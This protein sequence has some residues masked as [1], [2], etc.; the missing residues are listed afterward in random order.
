MCYNNICVPSHNQ[1]FSDDGEI[2]R[3]DQNEHIEQVSNQK[4]PPDNFHMACH[5]E[6]QCALSADVYQPEVS[7]PTG[8]D[9][10]QPL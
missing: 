4:L 6:V 2:V 10:P 9:S 3:L 8:A 5:S 1:K 7:Y